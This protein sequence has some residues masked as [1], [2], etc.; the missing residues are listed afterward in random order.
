MDFKAK[1]LAEMAKKRKAVSG[2]EVKEG[3][4][5]FVKGADLE[6]KRNQEYERKQQEIASKKRVSFLLKTSL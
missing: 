1:L 4:A 3:N 2:M 6:M 5:K